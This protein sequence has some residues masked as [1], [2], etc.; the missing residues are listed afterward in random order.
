MADNEKNQQKQETLVLLA[1]P[2][3]FCHRLTL[4]GEKLFGYTDHGIL[5]GYVHYRN[6]GIG[7]ISDLCISKKRK[8]TLK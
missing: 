3:V 7:S 1:S 5:S 6:H 4:L 8:Y 2:R